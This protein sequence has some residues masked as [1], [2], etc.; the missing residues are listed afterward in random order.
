MPGGSA[1]LEQYGTDE[2]E[3]TKAVEVDQADDTR[4]DLHQARALAAI[5]GRK[6]RLTKAGMWLLGIGF[7]GAGLAA[8]LN[9]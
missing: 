3:L 5:V 8:L 7:A 2:Q 9:I 1:E 6:Y 4:R